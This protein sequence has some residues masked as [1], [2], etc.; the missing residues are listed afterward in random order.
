MTGANKATLFPLVM[1]A[2]CHD[3]DSRVTVCGSVGVLGKATIV[4]C[5]GKV[6][7][8]VGW[9][10]QRLWCVGEDNNRCVLG[11]ELKS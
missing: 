2:W 1:V 9:E 5:W 8:V 3:S 11:K 4:V 10:R 7:I 6:A